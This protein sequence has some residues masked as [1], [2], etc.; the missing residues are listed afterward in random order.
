MDGEDA[1]ASSF[2]LDDAAP[3]S[4]RRCVED[5]E[6][7]LRSDVV[8]LAVAGRRIVRLPERFESSSYEIA[9]GSNATCT[10][11]AVP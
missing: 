4:A 2:R 10:A 11:S 1:G 9:V 7:V 8:A 6:P 3:S 5:H